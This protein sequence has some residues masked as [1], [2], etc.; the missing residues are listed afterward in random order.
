MT[1]QAKEFEKR[2]K[3]VEKSKDDLEKMIAELNAN[4]KE[5]V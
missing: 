1:K 3:N 2:L 4:A 5:K